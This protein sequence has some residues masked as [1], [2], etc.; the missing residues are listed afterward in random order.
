MANSGKHKAPPDCRVQLGTDLVIGVAGELHAQLGK[1]LQE[2]TPVVLDAAAVKRLDTAGL[3]LLEAFV[4]ARDVA[5]GEWR[6]ENVGGELRDAAAQLGMQR[7][8][9]LPDAAAIN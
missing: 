8:L 5:A 9:K 1:A 6:W 7:M 3:Q 4:T 2:T